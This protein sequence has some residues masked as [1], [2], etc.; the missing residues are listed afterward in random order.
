MPDRYKLP[1][2]TGIH[3]KLLAV[4]QKVEYVAAA[5]LMVSRRNGPIHLLVQREDRPRQVLEIEPG[6]DR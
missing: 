3:E 4:G 2:A 6:K 5:Y 1:K